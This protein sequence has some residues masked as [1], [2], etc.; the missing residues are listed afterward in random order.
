LLSPWCAPAQRTTDIEVK[1]RPLQVI[2]GPRGASISATQRLSA[3][4]EPTSA[5]VPEL[6]RSCPS[7]SGPITDIQEPLSA[8]FGHLV[9]ALAIVGVSETEINLRIKLSR[10]TFTAAC[11]FQCR[12]AMGV[13]AIQ[14]D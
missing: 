8:N 5:S 2:A 11:L 9:K 13:K 7:A 12:K 3:Y 1:K 4:P 6:V 10:G 14:L